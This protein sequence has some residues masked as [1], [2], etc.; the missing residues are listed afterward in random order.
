MRKKDRHQETEMHLSRTKTYG[1]K[2]VKTPLLLYG[3]LFLAFLF[4]IVFFFNRDFFYSSAVVNKPEETPQQAAKEEPEPPEQPTLPTAEEKAANPNYEVEVLK[5]SEQKEKPNPNKGDIILLGEEDVSLRGVFGNK[6]AYFTIPPSNLGDGSYV[7]LTISSSELLNSER[8]TLTVLLNNQPVK[9]IRLKKAFQNESFKIPL[10]KQHIREG[11]NKL[12]IQS[13]TYISKDLCIDQIDPANWVIVH[14]TSYAYI[15]SSGPLIEDDLLKSFPYPFIQSGGEEEVHARIVIPDN[16]SG[17]VIQAAFELSQYL[18]S[19]TVSKEAVPVEFE[20]E[21]DGVKAKEHLIAIGPLKAWSGAVANR[22]TFKGIQ[23][24]KGELYLHNAIEKGSGSSRQI[25]F[26]T[27]NNEEILTEKSAILTTEE[28]TEQLTGNSIRINK[29]PVVKQEKKE[30]ETAIPLI[31]QSVVL[32]DAK[33]V[34]E[35]YF[36]KVPSYWEITDQATLDIAFDASPLLKMWEDAERKDQLGLTVY[37]NQTPFTV[38]L[39]SVLAKETEEEQYHYSFSVPK[40]LITNEDLLSV[41]FEFNYPLTQE[42]C[43]QNYKSGNWVVVHKDSKLS[44]PYQINR[45]FSFTN[46]PAPFITDSGYEPVAFV[47]PNEVKQGTLSQIALLINQLSQYAEFEN[48]TVVRGGLE[49]FDS[50]S[51]PNYHFLFFGYPRDGFSEETFKSLITWDEENGLNLP[52]YGFLEETAKYV[53]WIQR[54]AWN[55][56]K[57]AVFFHPLVDDAKNPYLHENFFDFLSQMDRTKESNIIVLNKANQA[58]TF[59]YDRKQDELLQE[60]G[61]NSSGGSLM[62]VIIFAGIFLLSAVLFILLLRRKRKN[63]QE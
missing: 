23:L 46:W 45:S 50:A 9:S 42:G 34:S 10:A 39:S 29:M 30:Q 53:Y 56:E 32:N 24:N 37:L 8:S 48:Y 57:A 13:H 44:V 21:W 7:E 2:K 63:K 54:S 1:K 16:S 60:S 11:I 33:L 15:D 25:L 61:N 18:T 19:K 41:R 55:D 12:S 58:Q 5:K 4:V 28:L 35:A 17:A 3:V 26:V 51:L 52:Q 49:S 59:Y 27:A 14:K 38:P 43:R 6:D 22:M 36:P 20:S 31:D 40:E 47:V 62:Y